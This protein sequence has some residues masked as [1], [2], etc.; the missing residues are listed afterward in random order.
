VGG[1]SLL[2]RTT[3]AKER[4]LEDPCTVENPP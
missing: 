4:V 3:L 1:Q 2:R